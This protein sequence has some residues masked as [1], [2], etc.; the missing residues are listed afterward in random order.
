M[1]IKINDKRENIEE[2]EYP[3]F[4]FF[5]SD[6]NEHLYYLYIDEKNRIKCVCLEAGECFEFDSLEQYLQENPN[7]KIVKIEINILK[8]L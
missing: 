3:S 2:R 5:T 1:E 7:E 4:P 8:S 6:E